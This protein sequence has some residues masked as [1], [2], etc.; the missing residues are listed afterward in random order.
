MVEFHKV[1]GIQ[2]IIKRDMFLPE[3][4]VPD[5]SKAKVVPRFKTFQTR[6]FFLERALVFE[7]FIFLERP[8]NALDPRNELSPASIQQL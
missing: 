2:P 4:H 8:N 5:G 6:C 7:R 3:E 1:G